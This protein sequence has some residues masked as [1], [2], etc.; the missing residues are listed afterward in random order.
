M[1]D[2]T[3]WRSVSGED[4]SAQIHNGVIERI[5][6]VTVHTPGGGWVGGFVGEKGWPSTLSVMRIDRCKQTRRRLP[7][8]VA[9]QV[10]SVGKSFLWLNGFEA[11]LRSI[12]IR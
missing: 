9:S 5:V 11:V 4:G 6:Q 8:D 2:S 1:Y 12:M 3:V 7:S 10:I